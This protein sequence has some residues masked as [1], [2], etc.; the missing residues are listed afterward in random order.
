MYNF[1]LAKGNKL[2]DFKPT[3]ETYG[4]AY[5]RKSEKLIPKITDDMSFMDIKKAYKDDYLQYVFILIH[6]LAREKNYT[7]SAVFYFNL[8]DSACN[9]VSCLTPREL[10]QMFPV[11]K[12]Y[13]GEKYQSKDYFSTM[14]MV[15]KHGIDKPIG[16]TFN[17]LW[18]YMNPVTNCFLVNCMTALEQVHVENGGT[19]FFEELGLETFHEEDGE[20]VSDWTGESVGKITRPQPKHFMDC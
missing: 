9:M 16:D 14:E 4:R 20:L 13:D 1:Y 15:N 3:V 7:N 5:R 17:F 19:A 10:M 2:I 12:D 6:R 8:M 11:T 18:D